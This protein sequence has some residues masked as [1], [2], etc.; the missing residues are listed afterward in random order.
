MLCSQIKKSGT[1]LE[2]RS[3]LFNIS[4]EGL[5]VTTYTP[6]AAAAAAALRAA[7]FLRLAAIAFSGS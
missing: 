5:F 1:R 3:F 2:C 7:R 4:L 6:A